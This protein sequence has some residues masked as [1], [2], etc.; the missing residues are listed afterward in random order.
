MKPISFFIIF[1]FLTI[2][3]LGQSDQADTIIIY[4]N[5]LNIKE[6]PFLDSIAIKFTQ[7]NIHIDWQECPEFF[8]I[9]GAKRIS[10]NDKMKEFNSDK[11]DSLEYLAD[12]QIFFDWQ[13]ILREIR[14]IRFDGK[15]NIKELKKFFQ[16]LQAVKVT[17]FGYGIDSKCTFQFKRNKN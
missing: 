12:C 9:R 7:T 5:N 4:Q 8:F 14:V 6:N 17:R 1:S 16:G 13:G 2:Y 11:S 10:L 3:A 15:I